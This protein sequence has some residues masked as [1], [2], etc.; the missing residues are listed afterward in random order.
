MG[1]KFPRVGT[2]A[3]K[4]KRSSAGLGL[5]ADEPIRRGDFVVEYWGEVIPDDVADDRNSKYL[6]RVEGGKTI[7]GGTRKNLA[8]YINHSCKPNCEPEMDGKRIFVYAKRNIKEG[9]ELTYNYGKEYWKD[10][11]EP[12]G[13]RCSACMGG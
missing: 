11:I 10:Y 9:E 3:L 6:F 2:Y 12:Y 4:V 13:C 7:D 5:F 8:R 1:Y